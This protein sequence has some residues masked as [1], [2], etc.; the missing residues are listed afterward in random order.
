MTRAPPK[1]R[2]LLYCWEVGAAAALAPVARAARDRGYQVF[3]ASPEP[4]R[5]VLARRVATIV[6]ILPQQAAHE[7]IDALLVGIG[8][9]RQVDA[10]EVW[11][12]LHRLAPAVAVLDHWKGLER[13]VPLASG[14]RIFL[15][16]RI[17]VPDDAAAAA[18]RRL[19]LAPE[20]LAVT[21][22]PA[23]H[24]ASAAREARPRERVR[25][26][27]GLPLDAPVYL[28]AS[29]T[30][31]A[32]PFNAECGAGCHVLERH[33]VGGGTVLDRVTDLARRD[34][35]LLVLRP[36]PAQPPVTGAGGRSI[37]WERADDE[38]ILGAVDRVYGISSMLLP[39]AVARGLDAA[40]L[41]P[42]LD[43]WTPAQSFLD[44]ALWVQVSA[45]GCFGRFG[46]AA[47]GRPDF[48]PGAEA[49]LAIIGE[50]CELRKVTP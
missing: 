23:L 11:R 40:N 37:S 21:G 25:E 14:Q 5:T 45:T 4:A 2:L 20:C 49:V 26:E 3:D 18:L 32:H 29:E 41:A 8:H 16:D 47:T 19:G 6:Q 36:H 10:V 17:C 35:A 30:L 28:L 42:L 15:P 24:A 34:G 50:L 48:G 44:A 39:L 22:H 38:A 1:L 27:L 33:T 46:A 13:F 43:D 7:R 12:Q 9:P 31:H